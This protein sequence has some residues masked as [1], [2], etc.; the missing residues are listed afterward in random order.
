MIGSFFRV[1]RF[2]EKA[3]IHGRDSR[4]PVDAIC[5]ARKDHA[6]DDVSHVAR[7]ARIK[8]GETL[9]LSRCADLPTTRRDRPGK[10]GAPS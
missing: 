8:V 9:V 5:G 7:K 4:S 6:M 3:T 10:S 2:D 1:R